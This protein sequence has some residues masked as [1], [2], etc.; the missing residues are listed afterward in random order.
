M[1]K[2]DRVRK[3][4]TKNIEA[5]VTY[6]KMLREA[7]DFYNENYNE[8]KFDSDDG[9][10]SRQ[11]WVID[12]FREKYPDSKMSDQGI[13]DYMDTLEDKYGE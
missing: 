2:F 3:L 7:A 4:V 1:T 9:L 8:I 5:S 12:H 11:L 13:L 10:I 6:N